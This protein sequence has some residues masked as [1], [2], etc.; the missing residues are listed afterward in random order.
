[1]EIKIKVNNYTHREQL[2][3]LL[4]ENGCTVS[5]SFKKEFPMGEDAF[6]VFTLPKES[7]E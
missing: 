3:F 1:M 4:A 7:S 6:V 2:V 5:V